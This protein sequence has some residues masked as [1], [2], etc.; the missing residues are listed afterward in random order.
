MSQVGTEIE[1]MDSILDVSWKEQEKPG[2]YLEWAGMGS[3]MDPWTNNSK[4][5]FWEFCDKILIDEV[6]QGTLWGK[7]SEMG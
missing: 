1:L 2:W 3:E 4:K 5:I 6:F 7:G